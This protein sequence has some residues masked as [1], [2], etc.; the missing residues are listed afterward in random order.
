MSYS[1]ICLYKE[2]REI[3]LHPSDNT[4]LH[5][6]LLFRCF[7]QLLAEV[8]H[9]TYFCFQVFVFLCQTCTPLP[10]VNH[11]LPQNLSVCWSQASSTE[12][13]LDESGRSRLKNRQQTVASF[14]HW[15]MSISLYN[16]CYLEG[17]VNFHPWLNSLYQ[18]NQETMSAT[19]QWFSV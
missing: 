15:I 1:N 8:T 12:M 6:W 13:L 4:A 2:Y 14:I 16:Y 9:W 3:V 18:L 19:T 5:L 7:K 17:W 11:L 10:Q